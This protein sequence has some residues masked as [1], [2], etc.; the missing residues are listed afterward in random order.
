[1]PR[2]I[3]RKFLVKDPAWRNAVVSVRSIR[4]GYLAVNDRCGVRVRIDGHT[5]QINIKS[6]TLDILRDE[7][8]YPVPLEHAREMLS[9]LCGNVIEKERHLVFDGGRRWEVDVFAADNAGLVVA[10]IELQNVDE[11]FERPDWLGEEVS[12]DPRYMNSYL[13]EY[14]YVTWKDGDSIPI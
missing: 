4:Q 14:P 6:A 10:E 8:E 12:A 11:V 13:A 3:E 2:E 7:Y 1:M 9:R 5:A